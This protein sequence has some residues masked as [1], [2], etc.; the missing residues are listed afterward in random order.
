MTLNSHSSFDHGPL[1]PQPS[2]A[3]LALAELGLSDTEMA[4]YF[5]VRAEVIRCLRAAGE[6][7]RPAGG[8]GA[9]QRRTS[10]GR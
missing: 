6:A 10:R 8:A 1:G 3:V 9:A 5:G 4:R 7:D 2:R